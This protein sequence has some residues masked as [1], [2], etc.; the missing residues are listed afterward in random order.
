VR[1]GFEQGAQ[2]W[3]EAYRSVGK[4]LTN[5]RWTSFG[6]EMR[7]LMSKNRCLQLTIGDVMTLGDPHLACVEGPIPWDSV[8]SGLHPNDSKLMNHGR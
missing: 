8:Y 1:E 2:S 5:S 6:L 4:N 7:H 3:R